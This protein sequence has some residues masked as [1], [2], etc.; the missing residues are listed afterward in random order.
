MRQ[1]RK[2]EEDG[3]LESKNTN[4]TCFDRSCSFVTMNRFSIGKGDKSREQELEQEVSNLKSSLA[5]AQQVCRACIFACVVCLF[6]A[7]QCAILLFDP[8]KASFLR[9][10][11]LLCIL[12][13]IASVSRFCYASFCVYYHQ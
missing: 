1:R 3:K 13:A 5:Q 7:S 10:K 8:F 2:E 6:K 4:Y 11:S 9:F 12:F